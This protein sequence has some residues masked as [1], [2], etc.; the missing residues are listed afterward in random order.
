MVIIIKLILSKLDSN[1][2]D[3]GGGETPRWLKVIA[4]EK[5]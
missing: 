4:E 2:L 1:D 5:T 3:R